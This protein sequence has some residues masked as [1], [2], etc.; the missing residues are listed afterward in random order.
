MI[1]PLLEEKMAEQIKS[2]EAMLERFK[3][4]MLEKMY[5]QSNL[6]LDQ[7]KTVVPKQTQA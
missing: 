2:N 3:D 6:F 7:I 1:E 5:E 4:S